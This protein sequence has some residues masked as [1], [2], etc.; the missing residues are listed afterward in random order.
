M[1]QIESRVRGENRHQSVVRVLIDDDDPKRAVALRVERPEESMELGLA[2]DRCDN[3]IECHRHAQKAIVTGDEV[4][5]P[6]RPLVSVAL[7]TR[8][9]GAYLP[10]AVRSILRQTLGDLELIVVDDGSTD[11]TVEVL[12]AIAD[13]RLVV[14]RNETSLGLAAS[15]NRALEMARGRYVARL[16]ADDVALPGRLNRQLEAITSRPGLAVLGSGILELDDAG[17]VGRL[18]QLPAGSVAVRWHALFRTPF[19][20]PSVLLDRELLDE[21]GLRY[22]ETVGAAQDFELW[23]RVLAVADGANLCEPLVLRRVHFGR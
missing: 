16:D 5:R 17:R 19:F 21:H 11:E 12:D 13:A 1:E 18:H 4:R 2:L 8:D 22:D 7:A 10:V 15:L 23:T 9:A 14:L 20:H 3:E 6:E